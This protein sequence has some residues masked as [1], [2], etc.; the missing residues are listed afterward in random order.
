MQNREKKIGTNVNVLAVAILIRFTNLFLKNSS[1]FILIIL[2]KCIFII[3]H[4]III[5]NQISQISLSIKYLILN[6]IKSK[7]IYDYLE[8]LNLSISYSNLTLIVFVSIYV[9]YSRSVQH[10]IRP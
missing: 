10:C 1:N 7:K 3:N 8:R 4:L 9:N 6:S 2:T 5:N